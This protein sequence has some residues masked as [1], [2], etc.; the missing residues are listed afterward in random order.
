[1]SKTAHKGSLV[2]DS[3]RVWI[4]LIVSL[5]VGLAVNEIR[6]NPLSLIYMPPESRLNEAVKNMGASLNSFSVSGPDAS[7]EEMKGISVQRTELIL[8]ARPMIFYRLGHIP[9]ALSLPR[10]DFK[11]QY[12]ALQK[13]L[14]G[15][16]DKRMV[17]YCAGSNCNDSQMV[18]N[19]LRKLGYQK[20]Q[21][22]REG[23][24]KWQEAN[25]PVEKK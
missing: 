14:N 16:Q 4:L 24:A 22:F 2:E 11:N 5:V 12:I 23:W 20:V 6:S 8:D 3:V 13:I 15:N 21:I 9:S 17:V 10:D 25:L 1:M 7:L 19:A 18:A